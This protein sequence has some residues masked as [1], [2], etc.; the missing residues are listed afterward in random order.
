M[1]LYPNS[2]LMD[3]CDKGLRDKEQGQKIKEKEGTRQ[4]KT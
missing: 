4:D 3:I 2:V 1:R